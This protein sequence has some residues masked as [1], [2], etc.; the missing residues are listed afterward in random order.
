MSQ[1]LRRLNLFIKS[2]QNIDWLDLSNLRLSRKEAFNSL[3]NDTDDLIEINAAK[4]AQLTTAFA[5]ASPKKLSFHS[6][7]FALEEYAEVMRA[8]N[9]PGCRVRTLV[10][11]LNSPMQGSEIT[12]DMMEVIVSGLKSAKNLKHL[13]LQNH[14]IGENA[15]KILAAALPYTSITKLDLTHCGIRTKGLNAILVKV[16]QTKLSALRMGGLHHNI[17]DINKPLHGSMNAT[18][19]EAALRAAKESPC[20]V[21]LQLPKDEFVHN[22]QNFLEKG[23]DDWGVGYKTSLKLARDINETQEILRKRRD[24]ARGVAWTI[25]GKETPLSSKNVAFVKQ[26][27]DEGVR[28][29]LK[30]ILK[31]N[32]QKNI[33]DALDQQ[34]DELYTQLNSFK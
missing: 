18:C 33:D 5:T 13:N 14:F 27:N 1:A 11:S 23:A 22:A 9:V 16:P 29:H 34:M 31:H 7:H 8:I 30:G 20:L 19:T 4:L 24:Y 32:K 26:G 25:F 21:E 12:E 2:P 28:S 6:Q 17:V 3:L 15:A 10:L